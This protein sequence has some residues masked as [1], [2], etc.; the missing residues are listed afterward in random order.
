MLQATGEELLPISSVTDQ[1]I[2]FSMVFFEH[3]QHFWP[4]KSN[5]KILFW[6]LV[7]ITR[8]SKLKKHNNSATRSASMVAELNL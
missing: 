3:P 1:K 7:Q 8:T 2:F 5:L 6:W 4:Q